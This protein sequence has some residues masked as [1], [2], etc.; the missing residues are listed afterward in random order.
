M[1]SESTRLFS[2]AQ[3]CAGRPAR[4]CSISSSISLRSVVRNVSG[5]IE[6]FYM[7]SGVAYPVM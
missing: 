1:M 7:A 6:S 2:F 3:I 4:A 5:A